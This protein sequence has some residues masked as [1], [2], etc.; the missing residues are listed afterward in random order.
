MNILLLLLILVNGQAQLTQFDTQNM[1]ECT[2]KAQSFL[3]QVKAGKLSVKIE[4]VIMV[5]CWPT[6]GVKTKNETF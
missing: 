4:D 1:E 3:A 5:G 2:K 6:N